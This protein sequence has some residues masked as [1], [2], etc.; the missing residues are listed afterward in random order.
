MTKRLLHLSIGLEAIGRDRRSLIVDKCRGKAPY[1]TH[2]GPR[3][4]SRA[5]W[6][7]VNLAIQHYLGKSRMSVVDRLIQ[8]DQLYGIDVS[9][10]GQEATVQSDRGVHRLIL[11]GALLQSHRQPP[12]GKR[13]VITAQPNETY[14]MAVLRTVR[15]MSQQE[16][17]LLKDAVDWVEAYDLANKE[18]KL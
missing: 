3:G 10:S 12:G 6:F 18:G 5:L 8:A 16:R 2:D 9:P 17:A 1:L 7:D 11:A 13:T 15:L 4:Q 14:P